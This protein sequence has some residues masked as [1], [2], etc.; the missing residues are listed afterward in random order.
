VIRLAWR[1]SHTLARDECFLVNLSWTERGAPANNEACLQQTYWYIDSL[2]YL[3]ADQETGR[4]YYWTVRL[5]RG[6]TSA[7][8]STTYIPLSPPSEER[9]FYWK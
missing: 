6:Q 2:L 9:Y 4:I 8:G 5:A 1:S 7:E 3:R